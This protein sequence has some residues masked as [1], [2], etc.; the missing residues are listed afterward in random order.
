MSHEQKC[1]IIDTINE[2][3][4]YIDMIMN[5]EDVPFDLSVVV[6]D[7]P[8]YSES[9]DMK[10]GFIAG[11]RQMAIIMK[12]LINSETLEFDEANDFIKQSLTYEK[13]N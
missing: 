1:H 11:V 5:K 3:T 12:K 7:Y 10:I 8:E 2:T 13:L 4:Y 9:N 6:A